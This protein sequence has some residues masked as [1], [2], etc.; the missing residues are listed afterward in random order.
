MSILIAYASKNKTTETCAKMLGEKLPE[1]EII[2][3]SVTKPDLSLYDTVVIGSCIRF[4]YIHNDVKNFI[5]NNI[6][7]LMK[8]RTAIYLCCAF[9]EKANQYVLHNFPKKLLN[10]STSIECFGGRL[11][12]KP[13]RLLDKF[14]IKTVVKNYKLDNRKFPEI[15]IESVEKMVKE[16]SI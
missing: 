12:V 6:D 11:K 8:K 14:I 10:N 7:E 5:G 2:N 4:N 3:L 13:L 15:D 9:P 16:L 1:S